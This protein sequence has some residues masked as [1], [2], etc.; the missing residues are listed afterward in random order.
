MSF[1]IYTPNWFIGIDSLIEFLIILILILIS[2]YS[3][4]TYLFSKNN[5]Y[6]YLSIAFIAMS[7]S[8]L[9][10]IGSNLVFS[11]IIYEFELTFINYQTLLLF[12][13]ITI[14]LHKFLLI[15]SFLLFLY[16]SCK[17]EKYKPLVGISLILSALIV[18]IDSFQLFITLILLINILIISNFIYFNKNKNTVLL[19]FFILITMSYSILILAPFSSIFYVLAEIG[20]LFSFSTLLASFIKI[21]KK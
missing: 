5:N 19:S 2:I 14:T 13:I 7:L 3:Y 17:K 9:F 6:F 21:F 1:Y 4:K 10:K 8:Y 18:I 12:D 15:L 11:I 20:L 16:V